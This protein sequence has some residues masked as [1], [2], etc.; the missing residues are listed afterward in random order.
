MKNPV[1]NAYRSGPD[2]AALAMAV[3]CL[4]LSLTP[5]LLVCITPVTFDEL[6]LV[7]GLHRIS[8]IGSACFSACVFLSAYSANQGLSVAVFVFLGFFQLFIACITS[9]GCCSGLILWAQGQVTFDQI[10]DGA[11]ISAVLSPLG[12][13][14]L[15]AGHCLRLRWGRRSL[16]PSLSGK[17]T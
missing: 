11:L 14:C 4:V 12:S 2:E 9:T 13:S 5:P 16:K 15:I 3:L 17:R 1:R 6:N 10:P 8:C 7:D